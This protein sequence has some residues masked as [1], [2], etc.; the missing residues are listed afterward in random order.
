MGGTWNSHKLIRI[1]SV[2]PGYTNTSRMSRY[3]A[4][5]LSQFT[6][7]IP[8]KRMADPYEI[9]SAVAFLCMKASS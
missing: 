7:Q 3:T 9:A 5:Q 4:E 1:N 6:D 8:L 2:A